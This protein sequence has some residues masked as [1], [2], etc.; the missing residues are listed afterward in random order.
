M[1]KG[2]RSQPL[3]NTLTAVGHPIHVRKF[4]GAPD[5]HTPHHDYPDQDKISIRYRIRALYPHPRKDLFQDQRDPR[6]TGYTVD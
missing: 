2:I 3:E 1:S 5:T 4:R 6:T